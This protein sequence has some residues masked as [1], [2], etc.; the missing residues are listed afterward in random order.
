MALWSDS[1]GWLPLH[2]AC[3]NGASEDVVRLL[4]EA[5]PGG[6]VEVDKRQRT[7]LHFAL[8]NNLECPVSESLAKMLVRPFQETSAASVGDEND[9][10][11]I[12]YAC[13]YGSSEEVLRLIIEGY[14]GGVVRLDF[15]GRSPLHFVMGNSDRENSVEVMK[16]ILK[17]MELLE[18]REEGDYWDDNVNSNAANVSKTMIN[19]MDHEDNLPLHLLSKKAKDVTKQEKELLA[20]PTMTD[21]GIQDFELHER[22]QF[23]VMSKE[24]IRK[25]LTLYL[26]A[27]PETTSMFLKGIQFLPDWI[28]D[29]AVLHPTIQHMLNRK[30]SHR[31]PT[32]I[33]VLDFYLN[34]AIIACFSMVSFKS[35]E[36]RSDP[37]NTTMESKAVDSPLIVIIYF[38]AVYFLLREISQAVS[39]KLQKGIVYYIHDPENIVNLSFIFLTFTFTMVIANGWGS[40]DLFHGGSAIAIGSCYLQI[41]AYLRTVFIDFA[42]FV[43]GLSYVVM[44]LGAFMSI[45][46]ITIMAF[47][48]MWYTVFKGT[49]VCLMGG[50]ETDIF[51]L[52]DD[53]I[54]EYYDDTFF[55]PEPE[56]VTDCEPQIDLPYCE[57]LAWSVYKTYSMLFGLGD[58]LLELNTMSMILSLVWLFIAILMILNLLIGV[59]CD[60]FWASTKEDAA[61]IFWSKRLSFVTDMDWVVRG[62]WRKKVGKLF[63]CCSKEKDVQELNFIL[64]KKEKTEYPSRRIWGR[65]IRSFGECSSVLIC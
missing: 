57:N 39:V 34:I 3:A 22:A 55:M 46:A 18:H 17:N 4:L 16:L 41:L 14:D 59:I 33:L 13:A 31:F 58:G 32:M 23:L 8:C 37:N 21:D 63:G 24:R 45:L 35:A 26:S 62:S 28:R 64:P 54:F 49:S 15:K 36:L 29:E 38:G 6:V 30:I 50:N 51:L 9:M 10:L 42:V 48:Q 11:P 61:I 25:C 47:S 53:L 19:T 5:Y 2:Y 7:P 44:R 56:E 60:L 1:F 12:H 52:I 43:S 20:A 27:E 65:F 40:D